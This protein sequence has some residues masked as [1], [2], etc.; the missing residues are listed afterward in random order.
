MIYLFCSSKVYFF[1]SDVRF[2]L[3]KPFKRMLFSLSDVQTFKQQNHD[4]WSHRSHVVH[5]LVQQ[6]VLPILCLQHHRRTGWRRWLMLENKSFIALNAYYNIQL[7]W[8]SEESFKIQHFLSDSLI[9]IA[10]FIFFC[11]KIKYVNLHN[12]QPYYHQLSGDSNLQW[13]FY[14]NF[15]LSKE[16]PLHVWKN[17]CHAVMVWN[18]LVCAYYTLALYKLVNL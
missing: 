10:R 13:P 1:L 3:L 9:F 6:E 2:L 17:I 11:L 18:Y 16:L 7:T 14:K 12:L 5:H 8:L 4:Q 15:L